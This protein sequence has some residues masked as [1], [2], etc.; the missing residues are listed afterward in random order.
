MKK[1]LTAIALLAGAATGFSQGQVSMFDYGSSFAIQ[2]F[3]QE[4][5]ATGTTHVTYDG[6]TVQEVQGNDSADDN[7]GST[8][9]TSLPLGTG[10]DI[11][12][13][14]GPANTPLASLS[15]VAG[16]IVSSWNTGSAAGYW[17]STLLATIPGVTTTAA[18]AIAA[19]NTEG[20]TVTSLAAAV[21]DGVPWGIS[22][23]DN[24]AALGFGP[25]Q[26]PFLPAGVTSFSL[27]TAVPEP[28][29]IALGV[30]GA[31]AFLMRLRRKQ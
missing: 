18:V 27:G 1:T 9:Y 8:S 4:F 26:P 15:P 20:G 11:Q 22:T 19:W 21:A 16:S 25:Q 31:S 30:I 28:S 29:T 14:A 23:V 7:A 2:I 12:L 10:Y 17:N 13:L 5:G 24:T 6:S 3:A